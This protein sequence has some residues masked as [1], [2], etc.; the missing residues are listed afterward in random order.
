MSETTAEFGATLTIDLGALVDNW[1]LLSRCAPQ[2]ECGAVVK[3]DAYGCGIEP[4]VAALDRAGCHSFFVAHVSEARRVRRV[5]PD[6]VIYVLNGLLPGTADALLSID[7]RPV[8]GSLE[9]IAE[10]DQRGR[11]CPCAIHIDTGMNRLGLSL[12]EARDLQAGGGFDMLALGLVMSH[13]TSA[14]VDGDPATRRQVFSFAEIADLFPGVSKSLLN[15]SGHFLDIAPAYDLTRPGYAL[16]GG[17]PTP[18]QPNPM[19]PVVTVKARIIQVRDVPDGTAVGYNGR[20]HAKGRRRLATIHLGYADGY[21]RNGSG[22]DVLPGG[23]A[24]VGDVLCPF[25]G[26]VSMDLIIL[27]VTEAS[28]T[29]AMR[30][31]EVTLIGG[32]LDVDRV[33]RSAK[34][35]GY[36]M[37]TR[38]GQ[39][40]NRIYVGG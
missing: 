18:C 24:L 12:A 26:T 27:D 23:Q 4:V 5:A 6:A 31:G 7:A 35:V 16:Y 40:Y 20:W 15:S 17:N 29:L 1:Q 3:A 25:S 30:G 39:R 37:L 34:T 14:E 8:L 32:E 9:E 22:I 36:E 10:W 11:Q 13:F 28:P 33:A 19:S 21:P 2:A 38:L